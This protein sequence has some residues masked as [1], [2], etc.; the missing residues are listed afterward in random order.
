MEQK[1]WKDTTRDI[2]TLAGSSPAGIYTYYATK[3]DLLFQITSIAHQYI[4]DETLAAVATADD[5][6]GRISEIVRRSVTYHAEE[7]VLVRVVNTDFRALEVQRLAA[8]LKM[9]GQISTIVR[10]EV[11]RGVEAGAF[12]VGHVDGA[13]IAT[14]RLMDVAPW[15]NERGPMS[16]RELAEVLLGLILQMLG[17]RH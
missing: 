3:S 14:L 15:Y 9:R 1:Y 17:L 10:D 12:H 8:I 6:V 11:R 5:P 7:H 13:A 2:A 4:L 16:P